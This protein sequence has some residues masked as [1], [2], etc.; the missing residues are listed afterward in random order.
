MA[1]LFCLVGWMEKYQGLEEDSIK[2]GGSYIA[3]HGT[4]SEI[5]NYSIETIPEDF[6]FV[7]DRSDGF[8]DVCRGFVNC[9]SQIRIENIGADERDD[10]IDGVTVI[11]GAKDPYHGKVYIVGWY[12]NARVYR[13]FQDPTPN[14]VRDY[15]GCY[16]NVEAKASDC[17]LLPNRLRRR[18]I[19]RAKSKESG[20]MGRSNF[21]YAQ[22]EKN[23]G[24]VQGVVNYIE[25]FGK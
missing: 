2:G 11:W 21:W 4:G 6:N 14:T 18:L 24:I 1:M 19:P 17:V 20:G 25:Q 7:S 13:Y 5:H 8:V 23:E 9:N 3:E 15:D 12:K 16:Y 22:G 10:Y